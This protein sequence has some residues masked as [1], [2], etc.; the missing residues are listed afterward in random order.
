M[1][2]QDGEIQ[3]VM[4]EQPAG[5]NYEG[6]GKI[7]SELSDTSDLVHHTASWNVNGSL[8][9]YQVDWDTPGQD[10]S[11]PLI[12]G[13]ISIGRMN[14]PTWNEVYPNS[15]SDH[16]ETPH[17]NDELDM[18][19]SSADTSDFVDPNS[20]AALECSQSPPTDDL[21]AASLILGD[22]EVGIY[23]DVGAPI[24]PK[25]HELKIA[26]QFIE[27]LQNATLDNSKLDGWV[28]EWLCNPPTSTVNDM[29]D[30]I[31]VMI[32]SFS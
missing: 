28:W 4:K 15:Q 23:E 16:D 27:S 20:L 13:T 21:Q 19:A 12:S 31:L 22:P 29:L 32:I 8:N 3:R 11:R 17:Q 26:Q 5:K 1:E 14:S 30:P 9:V 25:I 10:N 6:T 18:L 2:Y 24:E 7:S